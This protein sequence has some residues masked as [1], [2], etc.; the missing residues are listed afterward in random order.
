MSLDPEV[1]R[2]L[3]DR[4]VLLPWRWDKDFRILSRL[5]RGESLGPWTPFT[6]LFGMQYKKQR[7]VRD[8]P[9]FID[10]YLKKNM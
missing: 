10:N 3:G 5:K 7:C 1:I 8:I 6:L 9:I 2:V 4:R